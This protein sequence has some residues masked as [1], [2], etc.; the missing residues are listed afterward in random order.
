MISYKLKK[1][2][3][4]GAKVQPRAVPSVTKL[5]QDG[6]TLGRVT[7]RRRISL[8]P[9]DARDLYRPIIIG[10][11]CHRAVSPSKAISALRCFQL[12]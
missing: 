12:S 10:P 5:E 3:K 4:K 7:S 6:A 2:R 11:H 1:E 8:S 9:S